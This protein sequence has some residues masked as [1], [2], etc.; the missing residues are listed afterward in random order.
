MQSVVNPPTFRGIVCRSCGSPIR[1]SASILRR[2][3][4]FKQMDANSNQNWCSSV[5]SHRCRN[6]G[7]ESIYSLHGMLDF[8]EESPL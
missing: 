2:E 5:F 1:V 8:E 7:E 3:S 6:C 4:M